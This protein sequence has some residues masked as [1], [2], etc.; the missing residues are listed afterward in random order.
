MTLIFLFAGTTYR[1]VRWQ[2]NPCWC[3]MSKP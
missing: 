2:N 1:R 3:L